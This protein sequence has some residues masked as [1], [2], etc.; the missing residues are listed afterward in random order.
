MRPLREQAEAYGQFDPANLSVHKLAFLAG[1]RAAL[2][3]VKAEAQPMLIP[4]PK[5]VVAQTTK[6]VAAVH[7]SDID[8]LIQSLEEGPR[9][10]PGCSMEI[11]S[12]NAHFV[13]E[14][15]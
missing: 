5:R 1:A 8:A 3:A 12:G 9:L 14:K 13:E 7:A 11:R 2:D 6:I 4:P 10:P 15:P